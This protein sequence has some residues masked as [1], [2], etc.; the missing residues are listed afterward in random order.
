[1]LGFMFAALSS[2]VQ[3]RSLGVVLLAGIPVQLRSGKMREPDVVFMRAEHAHRRKGKYWEG[4]DLAMELVSPG[5]RERDLVTKREE[6]AQAGFPEYWLVD[7]E[8]ERVT[9]L[10]LEGKAY[11]VHGEF[12]LGEEATSVTLPGF[13]VSVT[14]LIASAAE[15]GQE[16]SGE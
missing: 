4:A 3:A 12:R 14:E 2:F 9:V 10:I 7:P 15:A 8:R 5:G 1:I 13:S 16:E 6:H 11:R